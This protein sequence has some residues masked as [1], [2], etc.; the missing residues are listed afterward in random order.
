MDLGIAGRTALVTGADSGIGLA[1]AHLLAQ[2]GVRVALTDVDAGALEAAASGLPGEVVTVAADLTV[3]ADVERL[4]AEVTSRLGEPDILVHSA[5]T[6]GAT[7]AFHE[8]DEEGWRSTLDT[9][10]LSAVRVVRAFVGGMRRSGWG[11]IVLMASEDAVQPYPDELPYCAAKAALLSLAKGLSK[12]YAAEG[13]LVNAVSPAFIATPM[14]DVMMRK[15]AEEQGVGF[16]E[17][18]AGFLEQERP[19][20]EV[21]RRGRAEEVA[22]VVAF[23]CSERAAFVNGSN[24]RVDAGSVATI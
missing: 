5:G 13:V 12:T 11:R 20:I 7:G 18:V 2:E 22:A 9:D 10:F 3:P 14:T 15:R 19:G 21:G 24:Y 6:T 17:A 1:S 4:H 23:L 8:I 16:D